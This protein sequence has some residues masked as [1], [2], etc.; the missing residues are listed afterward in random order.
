MEH[1]LICRNFHRQDMIGHPLIEQMAFRGIVCT[2]RKLIFV[3]ILMVVQNPFSKLIQKVWVC[4]LYSLG[5][6]EIIGLSKN[7]K[8]VQSMLGS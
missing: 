4:G 5:T 8:T 6:P 1:Q 2:C 7:G 3:R